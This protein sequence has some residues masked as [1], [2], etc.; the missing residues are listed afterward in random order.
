MTKPKLLFTSLGLLVFLLIISGIAAYAVR[1]RIIDAL[2]EHELQRFDRS[3]LADDKMHVFLCGTGTPLIDPTRAGPCV[4][5]IAGGQVVMIDA[6]PG[7]IRRSE[8]DHFPVDELSS[9]LITHLHSDHIG[10]MG[11]TIS[12]SWIYGRRRPLDVYGPEGIEEVVEGFQKAFAPDARYRAAHMGS[13]VLPQA[14]AKAIAHSIVVPEETAV[15]VFDRRGLRVKAFAVDH[16]PV[17]PALG[18]RL[19]YRGR[20]VVISGDTRK[21]EQVV[22]NARGADLLIHEGMQKELMER[23]ARVLDRL[24]QPRW[25]EQARRATTYHT[26][27]VEA[28]QVAARAGVKK[29]V[30]THIAPPLPNVLARWAYVRGVKDHFKGD[31]LIGEDGLRIDLDPVK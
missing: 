11:D 24:G 17:K 23:A 2:I 29:L 21:S 12:Q 15:L 26:S 20:S 25:A 28:A 3:L 7:S 8:L 9:L 31:V 1:D 27:P 18:Y 13:G 14:G 19:D 22:L 4:G 5:V 10:G 6:G 30:L 16:D